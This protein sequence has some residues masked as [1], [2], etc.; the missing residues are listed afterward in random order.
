MT[1]WYKGSVTAFVYCCRNGT[2]NIEKEFK[3]TG[4]LVLNVV[5]VFISKRKA[6][7][8]IL[9]GKYKELHQPPSLELKTLLL[10][11]RYSAYLSTIEIIK[12]AEPFVAWKLRVIQNRLKA[13]KLQNTP[14][15][16]Y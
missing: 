3:K 6:K 13:L 7:N 11:S 4:S 2:E 12:K 5:E 15:V 9:F 8:Q 14:H 1:N 10:L 16:S